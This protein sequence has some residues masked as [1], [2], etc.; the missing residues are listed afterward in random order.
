M[1]ATAPV[2]MSEPDSKAL[3]RCYDIPLP[4]ENVASTAD[5]AASIAT[6]IGYPVVVKAVAATLTHKSDAGAV[7][8]GLK[9][10][11]SVTQACAT[12]VPVILSAPIIAASH[13]PP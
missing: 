9:N 1:A 3:L 6:S 12:I 4:R 11:Q 8:L 7:Q 5:E 10:S 2:A 13:G